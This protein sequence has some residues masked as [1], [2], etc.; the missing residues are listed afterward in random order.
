MGSTTKSRNTSKP[1]T[2]EQK[3]LN[4][5]ASYKTMK[6]ED[7]ETVLLDLLHQAQKNNFLKG[8]A[9]INLELAHFYKE[10]GSL[11][12]AVEHLNIATDLYD[13]LRL[14]SSQVAAYRLNSDVHFSLTNYV[15]AIEWLQRSLEIN[16]KEMNVEE[17]LTDL[18]IIGRYYIFSAEHDKAIIV[19]TEGLEISKSGKLESHV[20]QFTYF[21]GN[22]HN[23]ADQLEASEKLLNQAFESCQKSG[24]RELLF[25]VTGS[26]AIINRKKKNYDKA[27]ALFNDALEMS[28]HLNSKGGKLSLLNSIALL[29][30]D[31]KDLQKARQWF[32]DALDF[33]EK[34]KNDA[35]SI[36]VKNIHQSLSDEHAQLGE[37]ESAYKNFVH[38]H[39]QEIKKN[40]REISMRVRYLE[41]KEQVAAAMR[42]KEL[43]EHKSKLKE[44]FL[45]NMS[46]EIRTPMNAIVGV[47]NLLLQNEHSEQQQKYFDVIRQSSDNLLVIINDILEFAKIEAGKLVMEKIDFDLASSVDL[48]YN[49]LRFKAEE[50]GIE[51]SYW[52]DDDVPKVVIGDPTRLNQI[53]INL[54]GNAIKFTQQGNVSIE[55]RSAGNVGDN[56]KQ[57]IEFKVSDSGIG[58][59]EKQLHKIFE[60]F[61]QGGS[62]TTRKYGGTG[63]GLTISKQLIEMQG[64]NIAVKS[65]QGSGTTF[66]FYIPYED[67][68]ISRI[69]E[70]ERTDSFS[71]IDSLKNLH[72]LLVEDNKF[73]QMVAVDTLQQLLDDCKVDVAENGKEAL[74]LL[75]QK[76]YHIVLMDIQMPEM[77]GYEATKIIRS[78]FAAPLNK[79]P[80]LALTANATKQEVD[81]CRASGMNE[82]ISKPFDPRDLLEKISLLI[83]KS[84]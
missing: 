10:Q 44:Q 15:V 24:N 64:G 73:N 2:Q 55:I 3:I 84:E 36:T 29:Y 14:Q 51:L 54:I 30:V 22:A 49:T 70:K 65:K 63:L 45:A 5:L 75:K 9:D 25:Q 41:T 43:A 69:E 58:M 8:V 67:G 34:N 12:K 42:E 37:Y 21:L 48:V 79:I 68:N 59:S 83:S 35:F 26:L 38:Y 62:D 53:L 47:T 61:T 32:L 52:I 46:H 27:L 4:L 19:F 60:S 7:K 72:I 28:N 81:R 17:I 82:Y 71:S 57:A 76:S 20:D 13:K 39:E 80:I 1:D 78:Q 16:R 31:L 6:S 77:D 23:W 66:S 40:T 11:G 33:A 18:R 74:E 50:K 56:Q